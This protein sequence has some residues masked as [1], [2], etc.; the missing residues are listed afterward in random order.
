MKTSDFTLGYDLDEWNYYGEKM[1]IVTDITPPL[2][3]NALICGMAGSGKTYFQ[4]QLFARLVKAEPSGE[5]YFADYKRDDAFAH[6]R[7]CT[8]YYPY[9]QTLDALDAVYSRMNARMSGEDETRN[10]VTLIW[11]EYFANILSLMNEDKKK[12]EEVMRKVGVILMDGRS[13]SIRL[14]TSCQNP[15]AKA[16]ADGSKINY[17]MI[18]VLGAFKRSVYET[19]LLEHIDEVK[20]REFSR[21]EGSVWLEQ[22][23]LHFIKVPQVRDIEGMND[24][25]VSALS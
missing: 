12:A 21:G 18:I 5:F 23:G 3:S 20:G 11:D 7:G 24:L 4:T 9:K 6:L 16:F 10:P 17:G 25:C 19:A 2:N 15:Y 1:P 13:M 14:I 8:R 22:S